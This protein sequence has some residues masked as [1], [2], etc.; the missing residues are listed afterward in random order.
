[1]QVQLAPHGLRGQGGQDRERVSAIAQHKAIARPN[2]VACQGH[3]HH[4]AVACHCAGLHP[5]DKC[6]PQRGVAQVFD[7]RRPLGYATK[8]Q[9]PSRDQIRLG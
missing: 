4:A 1:M 3:R 9:R 2:E 7:E 6:A 8:V 5:N